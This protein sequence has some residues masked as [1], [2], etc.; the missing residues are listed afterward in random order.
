MPPIASCGRSQNLSTSVSN[1]SLDP[2]H[3]IITPHYTIDDAR[4]SDH[5]LPKLPTQLAHAFLEQYP[6]LLSEDP[7]SGTTKRAGH[8]CK[9]YLLATNIDWE[10]TRS[11]PG[12]VKPYYY[13]ESSRPWPTSIT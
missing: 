1:R 10:L 9:G 11:Y 4:K 13:E 2:Y 6:D 5:T 3:S 7:E 12:N 8:Q